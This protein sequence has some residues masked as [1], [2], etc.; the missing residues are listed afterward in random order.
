LLRL[1]PARP[2]RVPLDRRRRGCGA[3]RRDSVERHGRVG[4]SRREE[5][6]RRGGPDLH[7]S[8]DERR[9]TRCISGEAAAAVRSERIAF[10]APRSRVR[11][12]PWLV[13][14]QRRRLLGAEP[15]RRR[16]G[17]AAS[18]HGTR[19]ALLVVFPL[20]LAVQ[21][22]RVARGRRGAAIR[23]YGPFNRLLALTSSR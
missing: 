8:G 11:V 2:R 3:F 12:G 14:G 6:H 10:S 22:A 9:W 1:Y 7:W 5:H 17:A 20:G 18:D 13:A 16:F 23:K 15:L 4:F 19:R 21:A